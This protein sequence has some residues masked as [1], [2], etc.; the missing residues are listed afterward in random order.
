MKIEFSAVAQATVCDS[1][2]RT[3]L[4]SPAGQS[5]PASL[6]RARVA[7]RTPLSPIRRSSEPQWGFR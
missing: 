5:P 4:A 2:K 1:P 7:Q 6:S 3:A